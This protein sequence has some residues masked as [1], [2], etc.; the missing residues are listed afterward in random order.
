[1]KN[2]SDI[3]DRVVKLSDKEALVVCNNTAKIVSQSHA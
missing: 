2:Y 3:A 1:L